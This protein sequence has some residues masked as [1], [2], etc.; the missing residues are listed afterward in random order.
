[1]RFP[2]GVVEN[3]DSLSAKIVLPKAIPEKAGVYCAKAVRQQNPKH[4]PSPHP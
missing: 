3:V 2:A 1:M 4:Q